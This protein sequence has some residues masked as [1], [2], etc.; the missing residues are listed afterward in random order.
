MNNRKLSSAPHP[1]VIKLNQ[2][3]S[4][5]TSNKFHKLESENNPVV[6]EAKST[7]STNNL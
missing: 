7:H 4:I 3:T 5:S 6:D 1:K 2:P